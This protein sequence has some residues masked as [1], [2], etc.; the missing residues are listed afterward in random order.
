MKKVKENATAQ[1]RVNA[2]L[3]SANTGQPGEIGNCSPKKVTRTRT[4][5]RTDATDV[6]MLGA[7]RRM[8]VF[9]TE[10]AFDLLEGRRHRENLVNRDALRQ[11]I[12]GKLA[13]MPANDG[14]ADYTFL[15]RTG[16]DN[17]EKFCETVRLDIVERIHPGIETE[18]LDAA[19][20]NV[21]NSAIAAGAS[22]SS[23][24]T[25]ISNV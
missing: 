8:M 9:A 2:F 1:P 14:N 18:A 21:L 22:L 24:E 7:V 25:R 4:G 6:S 19:L 11:E 20:E 12:A 10:G 16:R 23:V 5:A 13:A 15:L 3:N 17:F